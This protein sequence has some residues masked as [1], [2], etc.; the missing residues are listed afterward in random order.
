LNIFK[1]DV[2]VWTI[3]RYLHSWNFTPQKPVY[4]AY[5]QKTPEVKKWMKKDYPAIKERAAGDAEAGIH[6]TGKRCSTD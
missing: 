2:S 4:K 5:E 6:Q 1:V 3:D